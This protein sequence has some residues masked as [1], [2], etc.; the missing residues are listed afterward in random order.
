MPTPPERHTVDL[1]A[2]PDL[3]V[4][5]LGMRVEEPRDDAAA[6]PDARRLLAGGRRSGERRVYTK[7]L[8]NASAVS[9]T[10]RQ[11]LSIVSACPRPAIS[12]ISVIPGLR[13]CFL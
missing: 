11:P 8:T 4:M 9:A 10:S 13:C 12:A 1:S 7:R 5:Y 3:V 6:G 2:Y